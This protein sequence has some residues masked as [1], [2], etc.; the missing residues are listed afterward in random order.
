MNAPQHRLNTHSI[1]PSSFSFSLSFSS[2]LFIIHHHSSFFLFFVF[3]LS[4]SRP[5]LLNVKTFEA[6]K[7]Y[8]KSFNYHELAIYILGVVSVGHTPKQCF[9]NFAFTYL[10]QDP[11]HLDYDIFFSLYGYASFVGAML[12]LSTFRLIS[13]VMVVAILKP[14]YSQSANKFP[15]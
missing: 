10:F 15:H 11:S 9:H 1:R 8:T 6:K 2:F 5:A 4:L 3:L 14:I 12:K 7:S 13:C